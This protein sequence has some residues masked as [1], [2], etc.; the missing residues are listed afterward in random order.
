MKPGGEYEIQSAVNII[1]VAA[2]RESNLTF[3]QDTPPVRTA[4]RLRAGLSL[5]VVAVALAGCQVV[6]GT[7]LD[8]GGGAGEIVQGEAP[9]R[10]SGDDAAL[11]RIA[12]AEH[13]KILATYGG[14]YRNAKLERMV[15]KAI[16]RLT[17]VSDNPTQS[18][19]ITIL[20]SPNVNA[21]ALPGG[22]LYVT[23]GL[24]ALAN[25][26]SEL[27]AVV[28]H[29]MAH[30]TANHGIQRRQRQAQEEFNTRVTTQ[31][32]GDTAAS[33]AAVVR[34]KLGL[35]Q[36]S[37]NQ[38]LEAD[39]IGIRA[40]GEAGIDPFAAPRFLE[41]LGRYTAFR[42]AEENNE[43]NLDFLASHPTTPQRVELARQQARTVGAPGVGL[44][45][46]D[47]YLDGI[48]GTVFGDTP[49]EG[50]VRGRQFLHPQLR[51][52]FSVPAGFKLENAKDA[53]TANGPGETA[54]RFDAVD[55]E[56]GRSLS[57]YLSSGWVSGLDTGSIRETTI[58]G[59][60]ALTAKASASGW[61]F[62][63]TLIRSGGKVYRFLTAEP[64][65]GQRLD[66]VAD[67][68]RRSF[69]SLSEAEVSGLRPLVIRVV[70]VKP[71]DTASSLAARMEG[72]ERKLE[73]F[74]ILNALTPGSTLT[75][76]SRV[77]LVQSG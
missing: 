71:G 42:E 41:S 52:A 67:E 53:V 32:L 19:K 13:P 47:A 2:I 9:Q 36:F 49:K 31:V 37:R 20:D 77:K 65:G 73:L 44:T 1:R 45:D 8:V 64:S 63:I 7:T 14:E 15:A 60:E 48:D 61:N 76:G 38:E 26:S 46:R 70:T 54:I 34:G 68:V 5:F 55:L 74:Q 27:S 18:Y 66:A 43:T 33:R 10:P 23:R 58:S 11:K 3:P 25:D 29:E 72:T 59:A 62:D 69:R 17:T 40:M 21:F 30:V 28:A 39:I 16:G 56:A 75:P 50:F 6:P 57:N 22:Y 51:V 12:E 4:R 24:I 35:A